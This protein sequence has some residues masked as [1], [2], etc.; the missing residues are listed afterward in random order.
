M[1][2]HTL[3]TKMLVMLLACLP[4]LGMAE[5]ED[6]MKRMMEQAQK[7]QTC[8]E[9]IDLGKLEA[10]ARNAEQVEADI[11]S[12]CDVGKRDEAQRKGMEFALEM[13]QSDVAKHMRKCSDIMAGAMG[14][15]FMPGMS[16]PSL[17][18]MADEDICDSY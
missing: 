13:S 10:M 1:K 6:Q 7:A 15:S 18:D 9:Q 3:K 12:L 2:N 5:N 14:S 8:M 17:D 4:A 11:E 16:F